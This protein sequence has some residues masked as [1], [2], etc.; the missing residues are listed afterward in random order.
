MNPAVDVAGS[1]ECG[2]FTTRFGYLVAAFVEVIKE[3]PDLE[4]R[5]PDAIEAIN[6]GSKN[7]SRP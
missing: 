4:K 3:N 1:G 6:W 5:L 7:A 2:D